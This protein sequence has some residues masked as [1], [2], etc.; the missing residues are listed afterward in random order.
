[1]RSECNGAAVGSKNEKCSWLVS[2][3][4]G[5]VDVLITTLNTDFHCSTCWS[6][7]ILHLLQ[8]TASYYSYQKRNSAYYRAPDVNKQ[9]NKKNI[10]FTDCERTVANSNTSWDVCDTFTATFASHVYGCIILSRKEGTLFCNNSL[11]ICHLCRDVLVQGLYIC[12]CI[13]S[14]MWVTAIQ[15]R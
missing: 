9:T 2:H 12:I 8:E 14:H 5:K 1:M 13:P 4:A 6:S 11:K 3:M 10:A 7:V 15:L